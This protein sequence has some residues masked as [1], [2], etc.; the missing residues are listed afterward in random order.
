MIHFYIKVFDVS[1]FVIYD[2][3][4]QHSFNKCLSETKCKCCYEY[5][6]VIFYS[7]SIFV[8]VRVSETKKMPLFFTYECRLVAETADALKV[9]VARYFFLIAN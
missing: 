6:S 9:S 7:T 1:S 5:H 8:G 3:S 2:F 4:L